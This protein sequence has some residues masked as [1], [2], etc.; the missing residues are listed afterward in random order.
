VTLGRRGCYVAAM[1]TLVGRLAILQIA[2]NLVLSPILFYRLDSVVEASASQ[3]FVGHAR[4]YARSLADSLQQGDVLLS[5]SRTI[6]FLDAS[7]EGGGS[8]YAAIDYNARLVGSSLSETPPQIRQRGNDGSFDAPKDNI[9]AVAAPIHRAASSGVLYLGFDE[10]PT[11]HQIRES[12]SAII[13]ALCVYALASILAAIVFVRLVSRPLTQLQRASHKVAQGDTSEKLAVNSTMREIVNL[14]GDLEFMRSELVGTVARLRA[15]IR[16]REVEQ[17]ERAVLESQLRHE[18]RLA[19]IGTFAS[20]ISHEFNN[21]LQPLLLYAEDAI[22]EL[23]TDHPARE[24]L[25][26]IISAASR[27]CTVTSKMLA[28]SRPV[29]AQ[30]PVPFVPAV[31]AL[32][33]LQFFRPLV[34]PNI[35]VHVNIGAQECQVLGDSTLWNQVVLNLLSNAVHAMRDEGGSLWI[36]VA[37]RE[38]QRELELRVRDTGQGMNAATR[39]RI[40]EPF[41]TTRTVGDGTGLGLSVVHGI[42][43]SM[44]GIVSVISEPDQGAEFVIVVPL[45]DDHG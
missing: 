22:D 13:M 9:F 40:F 31:V 11:L 28:F 2:V 42:V 44:G 5:P 16:S 24:N 6:I 26:Q 12:R 41:F 30:H 23:G 20:G 35:E 18:Q 4:A 25:E 36:S 19:T 43:G 17:A 8:S 1:N 32:E 45:M 7:I 10:R 21:I 39:E 34:P 27:A 3:A 38:S 14:A 15:S 37:H 29:A 33:A